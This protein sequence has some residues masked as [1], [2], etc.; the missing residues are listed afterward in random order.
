[1]V[2]PL[3]W[4]VNQKVRSENIKNLLHERVVRFSFKRMTGRGSGAGAHGSG[5]RDREE[6][7]Q[8]RVERRKRQRGGEEARTDSAI[9]WGGGV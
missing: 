4:L 7:D 2:N 8:A 5:E 1:M 6:G 3:V 9:G